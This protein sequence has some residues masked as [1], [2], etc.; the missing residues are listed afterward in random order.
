V[1]DA[2]FSSAFISGPGN[3]QRMSVVEG[4]RCVVLCIM[5]VAAGCSGDL[6]WAKKESV[7]EVS[8]QFPVFAQ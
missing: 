4:A 8:P 3:S 5:I 7:S 2:M 6:Q 1:L